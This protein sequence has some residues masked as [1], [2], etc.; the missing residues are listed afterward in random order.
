[1]A[2][3]LQTSP[4]DGLFINRG[5]HQRIQFVAQTP[6]CPLFYP[7]YGGARSQRRTRRQLGWQRFRERIKEK[8][9]PRR[10]FAFVIFQGEIQPEL[11]VQAARV[12]GV[13]N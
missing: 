13:S 5:G 1:M 6:L 10:V 9:P 3:E 2:D 8:Q 7:G 11:L 4:H 12:L